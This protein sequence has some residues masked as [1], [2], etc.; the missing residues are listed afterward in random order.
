MQPWAIQERVDRNRPERGYDDPTAHCFPAGIPRSMYV[1]SAFH[2][3]QTSD[4]V[5]FL[6]ERMTWRIVP[7]VGNLDG[8]AHLP[9][10]IRLWQGDSVGRWGGDTLVGDT[11][12]F[13]GQ[14]WVNE[15]GQIGRYRQ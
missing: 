10:S 3:V 9:D 14:S 13:N 4:Y 6:H 8:R 2:I 15:G 7:L 11:T 12:K 5:V 1:P